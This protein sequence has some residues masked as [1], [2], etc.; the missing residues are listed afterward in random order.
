MPYVTRN[1][2]RLHYRQV[3]SGDPPLVFVH[4][5]C[6][7]H[8]FFEPQLDHFNTSHTVTAVDLRGCG[9][10]DRPADGYDMPTLADDVA[11]LCGTIGLLRPVV[12][13]HSLGGMIAIELAARHPALPSA[14]VAV[15]PGPIDPLPGTRDTFEELAAGLEGPEGEAVRR[16]YVESLFL[17]TDDPER[18]RWIVEAMSSVPLDVAAAL[19]RGIAAWDGTAAIRLC[20]APLFVLLARTG[21]SNDPTRLLALEPKIQHRRDRRGWP[22]PPA[23]GAGAGDADDRAVHRARRG[24]RTG[25]TA[26]ESLGN[27]RYDPQVA[28]AVHDRGGW[29]TD[30]PIDRSEHELADWELL[31]DALASVLGEHGVMNVDELRRGIES[32]PP[33]EY[34]RA[35]YYERWLYSIETI[36]TEKGVL[37]PGELETRL[38]R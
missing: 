4:G 38:S 30:A 1:G 15:D 5:W 7:D 22:F 12:I 6:C 8:R 14:I 2:V 20:R 36:L 23:R 35:S 17:P 9:A 32:M 3:G 10:S 13:G 18:R 33:E 31:T 16:A 19:L 37:A 24:T 26:P 29:A 11:W 34:E 25:V 28:R 27:R 21:G